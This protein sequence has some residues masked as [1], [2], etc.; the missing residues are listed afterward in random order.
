MSICRNSRWKF[1]QGEQ[2]YKFTVVGLWWRGTGDK[3]EVVRYELQRD[4]FQFIKSVE[5]S[6]M[7]ELL[8]QQKIKPL[9]D[10]ILVPL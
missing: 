8:T 10:E 6:T 1:V 7:N 9:H 2:I 4:G 3:A 5:A